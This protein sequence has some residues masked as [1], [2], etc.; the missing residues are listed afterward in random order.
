MS[1]L[2]RREA[3]GRLAMAFAGAGALDRLAAADVHA[4]VGQR[5]GQ[6]Y[7]PQALTT[8]QYH[9]R[10]PDRPDHPGR[11]HQARR[12]T[13]G[14]PGLDRH[15]AFRECRAQ[16]PGHERTRL[17]GH[18]YADPARPRFR[19][20]QSGRSR[21]RYWTRSAVPEESIAELNPGIDFF[22]LAR[23]MTVDGFYTSP[24]GMRDIYQG[25][26]ARQTF[27]VPREAMDYVINRSPLK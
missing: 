4:L 3:I 18:D 14:R 22:I 26:Q 16:D 7:V 1:E 27:T 10:A 11:R 19:R 20:G 17:A 12:G 8:E 23:R 25:N 6:P 9:A 15:P 24:V 21:R 5:P 13:G 2:T